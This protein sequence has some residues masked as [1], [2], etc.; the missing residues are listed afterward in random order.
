MT[1][2][3]LHE[4][5]HV[6]VA[7]AMGIKVTSVALGFEPLTYVVLPDDAARSAMF[8]LGGKVYEHILTPGIYDDDDEDP[9]PCLIERHDGQDGA[10]AYHFADKLGGPDALYAISRLIRRTIAILRQNRAPAAAIARELQRAGTLSRE[11]VQVLWATHGGRTE[12]EDG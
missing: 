7:L 8:C 9:T 6:V 12:P 11:D 10:D 2:A 4:A 3:A 1:I 5:G